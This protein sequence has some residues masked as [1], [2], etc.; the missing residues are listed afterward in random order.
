VGPDR[1]VKM[2]AP[3]RRAGP[4]EAR[5]LAALMLAAGAR[6]DEMDGVMTVLIAQAG[7]RSLPPM[8]YG[9]VAQ[10][11]IDALSEYRR[12]SPSVVDAAS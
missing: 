9:E 2:T 7:K 12:T 1:K 10:Q 5:S 3:E 8:S 11:I 6:P 4:G